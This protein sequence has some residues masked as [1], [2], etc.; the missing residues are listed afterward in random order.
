MRIVTG[1][2]RSTAT[3]YFPFLADIP[4]AE[5]RRHEATLTLVYRSL[6][7]PKHLLHQLMVEPTIAHE[8]RLRS[9]HLFV[10]AARKLFDESS[11]LSIRAE[12]QSDYNWDAKHSEGSSEL[13][14]FV[15]RPSTRS[16][17]MGLL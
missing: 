12:Q 11:K 13:R 17:D 6:M 8:K 7:D 10:P 1:C 15:S 14:L 16:L 2:L 3:E 4:A 9:C 5:L